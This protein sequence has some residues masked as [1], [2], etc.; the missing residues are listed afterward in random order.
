MI[1]MG[2]CPVLFIS[3]VTQ[4]PG[5]AFALTLP[6]MWLRSSVRRK[7]RDLHPQPTS[8]P[9]LVP[10]RLRTKAQRRATHIRGVAYQG[11][12]DPRLSLPI[13]WTFVVS[14]GKQPPLTSGVTWLCGVPSTPLALVAASPKWEFLGTGPLPALCA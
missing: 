4:A 5:R 13:Q 12:S 14:G 9:G 7:N 11:P 8:S 3:E 6:L 10:S 2:L 1:D